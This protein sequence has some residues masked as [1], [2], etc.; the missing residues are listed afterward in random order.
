[1]KR[2]KEVIEHC[3]TC[4]KPIYEETSAIVCRRLLCLDCAL[5]LISE[6]PLLPPRKGGDKDGTSSKKT[7]VSTRDQ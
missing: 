1:M 3:K 7:G 6:N 5:D 4:G 2:Q